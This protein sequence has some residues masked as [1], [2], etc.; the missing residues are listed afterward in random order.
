VTAGRSGW[1][2][3]A[4][5]SDSAVLVRGVRPREAGRGIAATCAGPSADSFGP[6]WRQLVV[7]T[8]LAGTGG[9]S[10]F[11]EMRKKKG[12][13]R[14]GK[15]DYVYGGLVLS[16]AIYLRRFDGC[17]EVSRPRHRRGP[18]VSVPR[19]RGGSRWE[20]CGR[21][22]TAGSG[23]PRR[24]RFLTFSKTQNSWHNPRHHTD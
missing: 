13:D 16:L 11:L 5:G 18:K 7:Q 14:P 4:R 24:T 21:P 15:Q 6:L 23:D 17:G 20:T 10:A 12:P 9:R 2:D 22:S 19:R 3:R 1:I 8:D